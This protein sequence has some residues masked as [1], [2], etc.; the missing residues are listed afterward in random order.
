MNPSIAIILLKIHKW[1]L[2]LQLHTDNCH[3][4]N[5]KYTL[6]TQSKFQKNWTLK[7]KMG[8]VCYSI[9]GA[10]RWIRRFDNN[11]CA[12]CIAKS[13]VIKDYFKIQHVVTYCSNYSPALIKIKYWPFFSTLKFFFCPLK[14]ILCWLILFVTNADCL[15]I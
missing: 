4:S 8:P 2:L 11:R 14:I 9:H 15:V 7:T 1:L 13:F 3:N 10:P 12:T 5:S 6:H